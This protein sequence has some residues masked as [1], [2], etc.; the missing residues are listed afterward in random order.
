MSQPTQIIDKLQ[1]IQNLCQ[2]GY[3][4]NL[5]QNTLSKIID[6][7]KKQALQEASDLQQKLE[8]YENKYQLSS[9][10]F[11]QQFMAGELD[12]SMD[13]TEW[14]IFYD[15]WQSVQNRLD[16]LQIS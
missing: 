2:S 10:N 15:M 13:F 6:L 14:S 7:E 3:Q 4:S 5:I 1:I 12:D 16:L 8:K 11:Y 9:T